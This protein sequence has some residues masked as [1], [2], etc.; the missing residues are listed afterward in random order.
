MNTPSATDIKGRPACESLQSLDIRI[1]ALD[2]I[3]LLH[4]VVTYT[5]LEFCQNVN[6]GRYD[7]ITKHIHSLSNKTTRRHMLQYSQS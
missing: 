2:W 4:N 1:N 5:I 3:T 6:Y 7:Y